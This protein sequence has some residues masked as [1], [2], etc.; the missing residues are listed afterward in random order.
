MNLKYSSLCMLLINSLKMTYCKSHFKS[1]STIFNFVSSSNS[2]RYDN[3]D[4]KINQLN[5][6][7]TRKTRNFDINSPV[8]YLLTA[9]KGK[10]IVCNLKSNPRCDVYLCGTIHVTKS[11]ADFVRDVIQKLRPEFV[12]LEL[13]E[14]RVDS[15]CEPE[16]NIQNITFSNIIRTS[17]SDKSIKTFGIGLLVWMQTKAAALLGNKLGGELIAAAKEA[18]LL[19]STVILG[20]R[21][22]GVT[23]QRAFDKINTFEKIKLAITLIWEVLTMSL[24]KIKDYVKKSE[25]NETFIVDELENFAKH[26]PA[27]SEVIIK[28]RDE[29][30]SQTIFELVKIAFNPLSINSNQINR[31]K[32]V[33]VAGAGHLKGIQYLLNQGPISDERMKLISSSSVHNSTWPGSGYLS[34][35]NTKMLFP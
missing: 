33:V 20:D 11:S 16:E 9:Y 7:E 10:F 5:T 32:I 3:K 27:L 25:Q 18:H 14:A 24:F 6:E 22:Y 17:I 2:D 13:C 12:I 19:G 29:Y 26:L 23:I 35:V 30:I 34:I 1:L 21:L 31:G 15:L 28:E 8:E 4:T